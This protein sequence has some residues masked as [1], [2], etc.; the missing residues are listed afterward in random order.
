MSLYFSYQCSVCRRTKDILRDDKRVIPNHCSITKGCE[1]RLFKTGEKSIP[2][3]VTPGAQ[4]LTD[5]YPRGQKP[6]T[7]ETKDVLSPIDLSCSNNG[8][9]VLALY[10]SDAEAANRTDLVVRFT[11][12]RTE[13]VKYIQYLFRTVSQTSM[14]SGRDTSGKNLRF[15]Q[16]AID[17]GRVFVRVNGV[18]RFQGMDPDEIV[19]TPN[20]VAFNTPVAGNSTI[21]VSVYTEKNTLSRDVEFT[22]NASG[23]AISSAWNNVKWVKEYDLQTNAHRS[24]KWWIYT[25]NSISSISSGSSVRLDGV[26][27]I[28]SVTPVAVEADLENVRFMLA[29]PPY[30]NVDRYMGF[31]VE[32]NQL[33]TDFS[34][35]VTKEASTKMAADHNAFAEIFPPF[36]FISS[37]INADSSY[38]M[39]DSF[40]TDTAIP[41]DSAAVK[42]SGTKVLGP[43]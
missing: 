24:N 8:A 38:L 12:R 31:T 36:Q 27:E 26:F 11:Q 35:S 10:Q 20:T 7:T 37:L 5:W 4:G 17:E 14:I 16:L 42:L 13:D 15:D 41:T 19:L 23:A 21:D 34:I 39:P 1:G 28:D 3:I 18:A 9:I 2:D 33:S 43:L 40:T 25:S 30:E 22:Q 6:I 32:A 29:S